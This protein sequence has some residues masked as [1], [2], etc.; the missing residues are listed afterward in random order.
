LQIAAQPFSPGL[1]L[2]AKW[3]VILAPDILQQHTNI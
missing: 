2:C 3:H 1:R